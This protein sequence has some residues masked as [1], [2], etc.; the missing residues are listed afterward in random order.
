MRNNE[1]HATY[2]LKIN[3]DTNTSHASYAR[4]KIQMTA[5]TSDNHVL[6]RRIR[7]KQ[8]QLEITQGSFGYKIVMSANTTNKVRYKM[9]FSW[10]PLYI[11]ALFQPD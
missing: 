7:W 3:T 6:V 1:S 4:Y 10:T 5:D 2:E 9:N 11:N 8:T